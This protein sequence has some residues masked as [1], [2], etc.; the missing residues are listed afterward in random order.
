[1]GSAKLASLQA[2]RL[3]VLDAEVAQLQTVLV[4]VGQHIKCGAQQQQ[5]RPR[6]AAGA[7]CQLLMC[8]L[9]CRRCW[10]H[11]GVFVWRY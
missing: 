6:M 2:G 9:L 4:R 1:M 5:V 8:V 10:L 3:E 11:A 7:S